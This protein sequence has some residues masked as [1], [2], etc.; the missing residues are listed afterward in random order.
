MDTRGETLILGKLFLQVRTTGKPF[1]TAEKFEFTYS[2]KRNCAALVPISTFMCL[3]AIYI[4][5][6]SVHLFSCSRIG[7]SIRGIQYIDGSQKH[8]CRNW[9]CCR[10]F[11]FRGIFVLHFR[12]CVFAVFCGGF[13]RETLI[14][15]VDTKGN[16][17]TCVITCG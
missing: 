7:R 3:R 6:R 8:E 5:A 12:Y 16:V 11:P 2:Q 14:L 4:F 17:I 10:T 15:G 9:D 1:F 13:Y